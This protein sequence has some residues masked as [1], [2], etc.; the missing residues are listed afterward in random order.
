V[1]AAYFGI[2]T[3]AVAVLTRPAR[4]SIDGDPSSFGLAYED[5]SFCPRGSRDLTL[6]GWYMPAEPSDQ[7]LI[8]VHGFGKGG[9]RTRGWQGRQLELAAA[10]RHAGFGVLLFDLRGHGLS[11]DSRVTFGLREKNDV[12]GAVD[13]LELHRVHR[14]GVLAE[15]MGGSS[16]I[17]AAAE[18]PQIA[19]L[20]VDSSFADLE[21]LLNVEFPKR[22]GLPALFLPGA[23]LAGEWLTGED[24]RTARPVDR[25]GLL[26]SRP[27]LLMHSRKDEL[28]PFS[29]FE[30]LAAADPS[31]QTW[32][33][34]G[35]PAHGGGFAA[36]PDAYSRRLVEF[37][38]VSLP[39]AP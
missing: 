1:G 27:V 15:S 18:E 4:H 30:R 2:A 23:Y 31:A 8:L 28:I 9:G 3:I 13:W 20:A 19:A 37:F 29:H 33:L 5:V 12:L 38:A 35:D 21:S 17:L 36:N 32:E 26:R 14:I 11:G 34:P 7:A 39:P 10:L 6:R 22:S 24:L 25:I 16:A